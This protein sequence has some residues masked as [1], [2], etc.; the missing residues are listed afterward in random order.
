VSDRETLLHSERS[1]CL[2]ILAIIAVLHL[3]FPDPPTQ[4]QTS[5]T[6]SITFSNGAGVSDIQPGLVLVIRDSHNSL[7][8]R[9]SVVK[10][11]DI[12]RKN[13]LW[14]ATAANSRTSFHD[15][16]AGEYDLEVSAVGYMPQHRHV[17]IAFEKQDLLVEIQLERDADAIELDTSND[18]IPAKYRNDTKRVLYSLK[19]GK[20][21]E[22]RKQ[23]DRV[24]KFAPDSAQLNFLYGYLFFGLKD[25]DKSESY[26]S[27]AVVLDPR[28]EQPLSLLGRVQLQRHHDLDAQASLERAILINSRDSTAHSLLAHDYLNQ[29]QYDKAREQAQLAIDENKGVGDARLV[30]GEALIGLGQDDEGINLVQAFLKD[31]PN[32]P[33]RAKLEGFIANVQSHE[34]GAAVIRE[35]NLPD[36]RILDASIPD[37]PPSAWG[38]AGVDE[39]KPPVAAGLAC[40]SDEVI[41]MSGKRVQQLVQD[42]SQF[43]AIEDL[44]HEQLDRFG[45]PTT[46]ENRQFDYLATISESP[47]GY[48]N[49]DENRMVRSGRGDIPDGIITHGFMSLALIFHP[50]MRDDFQITCEGLSQWQGQATWLMY[51]R[52]RDDKPS[53]FGRYT[54]GSQPYAVKL[55][56][57]AWI[58]ADNFGIVRIESELM[59]PVEKL[60]VQHQIVEYGPVHFK[61]ENLDLWLPRSIDLYLEIN[62]RRYYRRHM[63]DRYVLFSVNTEEKLHNL[64]VPDDVPCLDASPSSCQKPD[65]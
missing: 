53:R 30:L 7:L 4:A 13:T 26:L 49:V 24:Y 58:S 62:R 29:K 55:K 10:L 34:Q 22:A 28:R 23:L 33:D 5:D 48:F 11:D 20:L 17:Q 65:P 46:K 43:A 35:A 61:N 27:R 41:E 42:V 39:A 52:H 25:L 1:N 31:N 47:P 36:D 2:L 54:E 15:L 59:G 6:T 14:Q 51:F 63:F 32:D 64:P 21:A 56:G 18:V 50:D 8:D 9:Q 45:N 37:L 16:A 44:L 38:P 3:F 12:A 60:S 57:R 19:S 40:P